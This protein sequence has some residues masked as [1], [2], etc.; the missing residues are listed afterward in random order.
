M[1]CF[2]AFFF[3]FEVCG[4]FSRSSMSCVSSTSNLSQTLCQ[5]HVS[6]TAR[7]SRSLRKLFLAF[8]LCN[9][10]FLP[11]A[12]LLTNSAHLPAPGWLFSFWGS[13]ITA[14]QRVLICKNVKPAC[15]IWPEAVKFS[16][17]F[18]Y[19]DNRKDSTKRLNLNLLLTDFHHFCCLKQNRT[20]K[21][22]P[23]QPQKAT[24]SNYYLSLSRSVLRV[25]EKIALR[26]SKSTCSGGE[27]RFRGS[28]KRNNKFESHSNQ[29]ISCLC[30]INS[31]WAGRHN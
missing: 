28:Q 3:S 31:S 17:L 19:G 20:K 7:P 14:L 27:L 8:F 13:E 16:L 22:T 10:W 26:S 24:C 4:Q 9:S 30:F 18:K 2:A 1:T 15:N 23:K 21:R 11:P 6:L 12:P 25:L 29:A 5:N